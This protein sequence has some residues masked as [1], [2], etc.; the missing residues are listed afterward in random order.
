MSPMN[1]AAKI[2]LFCILT[3][4]LGFF[5]GSAVWFVLCLIRLSTDGLWTYLPQAPGI[6]HSPVYFLAVCLSGGR[7][8]GLW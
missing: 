1:K 2:L 8:I 6:G 4:V 7:R 3:I 5:A